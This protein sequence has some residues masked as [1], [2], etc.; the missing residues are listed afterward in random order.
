MRDILLPKG[1]H[2]ESFDLFRFSGINDSILGMV[3]MQDRHIV[4]VED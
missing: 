4:A 2:S 3:M 1:M